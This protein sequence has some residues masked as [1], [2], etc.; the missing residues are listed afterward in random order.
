MIVHEAKNFTP[1]PVVGGREGIGNFFGTCLKEY[2]D[3]VYIDKLGSVIAIKNGTDNNGPKIMIEAHIDGVG[4]M[5]KYIEDNGFLRYIEVGGWDPRGI[6]RVV[7]YTDKGPVR[8][9]LGARGGHLESHLPQDMRYHI[10]GDLEG[11]IDIGASSRDEVEIIGVKIGD[12]ATYETELMYL[13]N[14]KVVSGKYFDCQLGLAI[15]I[16]VFKQLKTINHEATIYA[17]GAVQEEG[18]YLGAAT[19]SYEIN[20]DLAIELDIALA[21]DTPDVKFNTAPLRVGGGPVITICHQGSLH[22]FVANQKIVDLFVNTAIENNIP[23]QLE[24]IRGMSSDGIAIQRSRS[25]IPSGG[26]EVATR[27]SHSALEVMS[28]EDV[29]NAVK[30]ILSTIVK[31]NNKNKINNIEL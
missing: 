7:I 11:Y 3:R 9:I 2:A 23:Y 19:T 6:K 21:G 1:F 10:M 20:P 12:T 31:I 17:V 13:G 27:Y 14:N 8:G 15:L 24:V 5:I 29:E 28:L 22:R 25:G 18:P 26:I 30:L 4:L 16:E